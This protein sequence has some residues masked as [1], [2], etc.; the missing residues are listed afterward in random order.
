MVSEKRKKEIEDFFDEL[1][2]LPNISDLAQIYN[3]S[4]EFL[5]ISN[6][7]LEH[8]KPKAILSVTNNTNLE[9]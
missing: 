2:K 7:F 9:K 6:R 1:E 8:T 5:E 3:K 4:K